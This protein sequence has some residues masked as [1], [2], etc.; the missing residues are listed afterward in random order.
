MQIHHRSTPAAQH[1]CKPFAESEREPSERR[2]NS[3]SHVPIPLFQLPFLRCEVNTVAATLVTSITSRRL[4]CEMSYRRVRLGR[5]ATQ[6]N[7]THNCKVWY[8]PWL[9][10]ILSTPRHIR[11][12]GDQLHFWVQTVR[13]DNEPLNW[14]TSSSVQYQ[15]TSD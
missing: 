14:I 4:P 1:N 10:H 15:W 7:E 9:W 5:R 13:T 2:S 6:K 11:W 3:I 12:S 8:A